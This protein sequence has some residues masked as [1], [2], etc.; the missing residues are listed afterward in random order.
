MKNIIMGTSCYQNAKSGNMVS[1]T[2]DGGNAWGYYGPS[3]K[4]LAPSWNLYQYYFFC[5]IIPYFTHL[6]N[7]NF[8]LFLP[9]FCEHDSVFCHPAI[10]R[11]L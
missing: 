2:G 1:I 3:Y 4:K 9:S 7:I 8:F 10:K 11:L 5:R 6:C